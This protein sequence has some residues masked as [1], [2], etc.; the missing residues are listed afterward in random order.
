MLQFFI[1]QQL[2]II[3]FA[4]VTDRGSWLPSSVGVGKRPDKTFS[5][6]SPGTPDAQGEASKY[7]V[8]LLSCSSR[9]GGL[10]P[11]TERVHSCVQGQAEAV[12]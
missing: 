4:I 11:H 3:A 2:T 5:Q 6:G 12:P 1:A 10:G 7:W 8:I 9:C